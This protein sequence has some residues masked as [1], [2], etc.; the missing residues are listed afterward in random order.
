MKDIERGLVQ[1]SIGYVHYRATGSGRP[2]VLM[3]VNGGSSLSYLELLQAIV[4]NLL[5]IQRDHR[6]SLFEQHFNSG[7]A[8]LRHPDDGDP[9]SL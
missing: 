2:L 4:G 7:D 1:T 3:H 8:A 9:L 6:C 5:L